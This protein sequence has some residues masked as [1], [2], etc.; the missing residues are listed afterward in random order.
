MFFLLAWKTCLTENAR[1]L[2]AIK[3]SGVKYELDQTETRAVDHYLQAQFDNKGS[4]KDWTG[5]PPKDR[6][7]DKIR[8][9]WENL[10][11]ECNPVSI[12]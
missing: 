4:K 5:G 11:S 8:K 7:S 9:F 1:L 2:K 6:H 12:C 3:A 10:K